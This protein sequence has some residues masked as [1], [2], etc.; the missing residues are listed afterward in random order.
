MA[1]GCVFRR[2]GEVVRNLR[3]LYRA[4]YRCEHAQDR[5]QVWLR[6]LLPSGCARLYAFEIIDP[7]RQLRPR[8]EYGDIHNDF[9]RSA[10]EF[11]TMLARYAEKNP[12]RNDIALINT[13]QHFS[14][15]AKP[16]PLLANNNCSVYEHRPV[17][18]CMY[19]SLTNPVY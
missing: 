15:L 14:A 12:G 7:Y 19:H 18:C 3:R 16:C 11:Q 4:Q 17:S 2:D 5:V 1:A 13:L 8:D 6:A 10:D 9:V